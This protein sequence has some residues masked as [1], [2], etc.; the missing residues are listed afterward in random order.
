[1]NFAYEFQIAELFLSSI[2]AIC[3][4]DIEPSKIEKLKLYLMYRGNCRQ[5]HDHF[6]YKVPFS[7]FAF[8]PNCVF[9]LE[10]FFITNR[11]HLHKLFK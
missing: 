7:K 1:M 6:I 2:S 10:D 8:A 9:K 3:N 4:K 5:L 11:S